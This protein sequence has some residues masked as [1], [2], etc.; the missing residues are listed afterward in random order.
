MKYI[1]KIVA[2]FLAALAIVA[3]T[4][5]GIADL[6]GEYN[7][8]VQIKANQATVLET[9]KM[10]KGIK[11]LNVEFT[12][13]TQKST[14]HFYSA[15]WLLAAGEYKVKG[16][17]ADK[18]AAF[19][20]ADG[21]AVSGS[22]TVNMIASPLDT[23][24]YVNALVHMGDNSVRHLTYTGAL[25]FVVGE[26][27]PEPSGVTFKVKEIP[28]TYFSMATWSNVEVA[29]K[30]YYQITVTDDKL[31]D[32]VYL[33][34][35]NPSG[36]S[37]KELV[38]DYT[39]A[40][41]DENATPMT[42][43]NGYNVPAYFMSGGAWFVNEAGAKQFISAGAIKL[44]VATG[45]EGQDLFTF[46]GEG[47]GMVSADE[48]AT[49]STDGAFKYRFC[50]EAGEEA[51][52]VASGF[53]FTYTTEDPLMVTSD[54]FNYTAVDGVMRFIITV[55]DAAGQET[56][57]FSIS[58]P[59][60]AAINAIAGAYEVVSA[61]SAANQAQAGVYW[62]AWGIDQHTYATVAGVKQ[63]FQTGN[64]LIKVGQDAE[65]HTLY[66]FSFS[67]VT[68][69]TSPNGTFPMTDT[70]VAYTTDLAGEIVWA[71]VAE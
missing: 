59:S 4:P 10:G 13:G 21:Q 6:T 61:P 27:D 71:A 35:I 32:V 48:N 17:V 65:G 41:A 22:V 68:G 53:T 52:P 64:I 45:S 14:I 36:K 42:I 5:N 49:E 39:I 40:S 20:A 66:N 69:M 23:V 29:G 63:Y 54:G 9:Q 51:V 11:S 26:D 1:S 50:E 34:L 15:E 25:K 57:R 18:T 19:E 12:D 38:G 60:G 67:G 33:E 3:C 31:K 24:Y 30:S 55:K 70:D 16:E 56:A 43:A 46:T 62:P 47:L 58:Q 2:S 44:E 37:T 8:M 28:Y 7:D